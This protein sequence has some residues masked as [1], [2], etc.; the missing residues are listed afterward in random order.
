MD[1]LH[2]LTELYSIM[3][4]YINFFQPSMN[5]YSKE[6]KET[7]II[8]KYESAQTPYQRLLNSSYKSEEK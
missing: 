5:L 6:R 2:K 8:K 3:R 7:K 1:A 4:L